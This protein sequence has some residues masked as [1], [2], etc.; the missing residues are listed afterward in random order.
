M[1]RRRRGT[2]F[3]VA[4]PFASR[5]GH[6]HS[7]PPRRPARRTITRGRPSPSTPRRSASTRI[8]TGSASSRSR[9]ATA[10]PT[11]CRS[12]GTAPQPA[13]LI[14]IFARR[15]RAQDLPLR[16]LR[17]RRSCS[18]LSAS[19]RAR[20]TAPRSPRASTRTYTDRH[21]LKD[22]VRELIGVESLEAAAIVRLGRRDPDPGAARL[23]R[24]RRDSTSTASRSRLD[25][26]L[27]RE[28]RLGIAQQLLRLPADPGPARPAR[29]GGDGHFRA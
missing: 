22:L 19:C 14:R 12:R 5:A 15:E 8:A 25:G 13:T 28:H 24:L 1:R 4:R 26:M 7:L 3:K 11:W 21:G 20:S 29:L 17:P 23:C 9:T 6:D 2:G 27:E 16:P 10:P 18:T